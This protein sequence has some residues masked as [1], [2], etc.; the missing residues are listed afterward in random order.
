MDRELS[1]LREYYDSGVER[2]RLDSALW[3]IE[4]ER[5]K[6]ILTRHLPNVPATVADIGGGPGRYAVWLAQAGYDVIHRDIVPLHVDQA[7]VAA[8]AA[9]IATDTDVDARSLDLT[10]ATVDCVLLLGPLY[11]L[12]HRDDR[13]RALREAHRV[14]RPGGTVFV[15]GQAHPTSQSFRGPQ[16]NGAD[17]ACMTQREV[18]PTLCALEAIARPRHPLATCRRAVASDT[19]ITTPPDS[20]APDD[21]RRLQRERPLP[22]RAIRKSTDRDQSRVHGVQ[23][24][25]GSR[26]AVDH[27]LRRR[28]ACARLPRPASRR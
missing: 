23:P 19:N 21:G 14:V 26:I 28:A 6:E 17:S 4:F 8:D 24:H 7:R 15:Y 5:T 10:D 20:P 22:C 13:L 2:M 11:H 27:G 16:E 25:S 12:T 18:S 3:I 1:V 9:G